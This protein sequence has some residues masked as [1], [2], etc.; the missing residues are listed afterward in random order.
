M[1]R[2]FKGNAGDDATGGRRN[3]HLEDAPSRRRSE[4]QAYMAL[5][6]DTRIRAIA[7]KRW[8]EAGIPNMDFSGSSPA[9]PEDQ[10]DPEDS[11]MLKDP[12]VPIC[13]KNE[14]ASELYEVEEDE[15]KEV[16]RAKVQA[17]LLIKSVLTANE[18]DRQALVQEY[19]K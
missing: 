9:I 1:K 12:Q 3:L 6:Y 8:T 19:H 18:E 13:Y 15:I 5:F 4:V 2:V 17:D 10:I 16:V 11:A 7:V 14:V